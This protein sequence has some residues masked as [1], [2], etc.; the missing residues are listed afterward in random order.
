SP[1]SCRLPLPASSPSSSCPTSSPPSTRRGSRTPSPAEALDAESS[2]CDRKLEMQPELSVADG[3]V[4]GPAAQ[5]ACELE[6]APHRDRDAGPHRTPE[7]IRTA[8]TALRGRRPR[9][10]DDGGLGT[11]HLESPPDAVRWAT[12]TRT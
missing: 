10:L 8:V 5:T 7:Q 2:V 9:P 4:G 1:R 3:A 11:T 12:R 6:R